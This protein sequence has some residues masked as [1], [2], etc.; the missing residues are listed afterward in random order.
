M[1]GFPISILHFRRMCTFGALRASLL[2]Y[3]IRSF[4]HG[5]RRPVSALEP[6]PPVG[7]PSPRAQP[8]RLHL[9]LVPHVILSYVIM[10]F[11]S[12]RAVSA[13]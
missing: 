5:R 12:V 7:A 13:K 2:K 10:C 11:P 3:W 9:L 4:A 8:P 1:L 6:K